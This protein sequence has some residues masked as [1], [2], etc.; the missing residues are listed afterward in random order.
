MLSIIPFNVKPL[1]PPKDDLLARLL[2][3]AR[4]VRE[5]DVV[6]ISSKVVSIHE[7]RC[8][9]CDDRTH[10]DALA[11]AEADAYLPRPRAGLHRTLFTITRGTLISVAGIDESNGKGHFV[12]YPVDPMRSAARLRTYLRK[13]SGRSRIGVVITDS[14][15]TPLRRGALGFALGWAGFSPMRDYR[16]TKDIFGRT[17]KLEVANIADA[18]AAA[19]VLSMGEGNEA[20]PVAIVRG[21]STTIF[22][23]HMTKKEAFVIAPAEDLFAPFLTGV[24][25]KKGKGGYRSKS[26][27]E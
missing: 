17:M 23:P 13:V 22:S 5:G 12:L 26:S 4:K 9:P 10:K 6:A 18:L 15:S 11:I 27:Q 21:L 14:H 3:L 24:Q 1:V 7:G 19:A 25:W 8:V 2:P 20:T 16:G